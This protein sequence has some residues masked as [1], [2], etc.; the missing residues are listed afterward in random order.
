MLAEAV[1]RTTLTCRLT[2]EPFCIQEKMKGKHTLDASEPHTL[3]PKH[4]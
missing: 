4:C 3:N 1:V 2:V